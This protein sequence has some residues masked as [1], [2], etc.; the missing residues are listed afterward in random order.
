MLQSKMTTTMKG[1]LSSK[2]GPVENLVIK[3]VPKPSATIPGTA[4]IRVKAFGINHAKMHMRRGEWAES[5]PISGIECV[6][7]IE[8]CPSGEFI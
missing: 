2:F 4:L 3:D 5:V 7:I 6:G 1:V 8:N